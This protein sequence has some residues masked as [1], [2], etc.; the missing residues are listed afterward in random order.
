MRLSAEITRTNRI[1]GRLAACLARQAPRIERAIG[2]L[3]NAVLD[4]SREL[5]PTDTETLKDSSSVRWVSFG[6]DA[7]TV[8]GYGRKDYYAIGIYSPHEGRRVDRYPYE[9]AV[10]VHNDWKNYENGQPEF[11]SQVVYGERA[12]LRQVLLG[13]L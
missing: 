3:S 11:L 12:E 10:W 4:R 6:V 7:S 5:V 9:Y 2:A 8:V 13:A 1:E